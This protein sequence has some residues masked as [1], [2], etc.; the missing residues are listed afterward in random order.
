[1]WSD[2]KIAR[3]LTRSY[4]EEK[5]VVKKTETKV[6]EK[7]TYDWKKGVRKAE[8]KEIVE[9]PK[10]EKIALKKP[11]EI[12]KVK[13]AAKDG[14]KLKPIPAKAKVEEET[15]EG[16]KLKPIP[17]K[18][19]PDEVCIFCAFPFIS[20]RYISYIYITCNQR[21]IAIANSNTDAVEYDTYI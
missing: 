8:Q 21:Q 17:Q 20:N 1:M 13:E 19:K 6:E 14:P 10:P 12:E 18:P 3:H 16:P 5:K 2:V 9:A 11:K 7:K 4:R 15:K